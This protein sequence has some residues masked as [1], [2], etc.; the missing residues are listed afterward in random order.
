[1][2]LVILVVFFA[3]IASLATGL[4]FLSRDDRGSQRVLKA[5]KIR[6]ALSALLIVLLI[7]SYFMGWISPGPQLQ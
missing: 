6:V 3:V 7:A 5:L 2:K 1:M 4:F